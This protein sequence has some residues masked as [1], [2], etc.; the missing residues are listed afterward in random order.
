MAASPSGSSTSPQRSDYSEI[1]PISATHVHRTLRVYASCSDT[2]DVPSV[3]AVDAKTIVIADDTAFVR[4]RFKSALQ[5]AGHRATTVASA[6]ELLSQIRTHTGLVHLVVLDLRLPQAQGVALVRALRAIDGFKAPI[7]VFSGTIANADEV[8]EL[9]ALGIAG[10]INEYSAVQNIVPALA[11]HLFPEQH[12]RR[13]GPRVVLGIPVAYRLANTIAAALTLNIS[14]GGLAI[15]TT[16]PLDT[17]TIVKVRFRLP[18]GAKDVDAEARVAWADR[19]T[20][21]G[22]QFTKVTPADQTTIDDF[23]RKH[24]FSNRK[25]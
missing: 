6:N 24:F 8:R 20:G 14:H 17:G 23:V 15:R 13:M 21:M 16:N 25:A 4:D 18:G 9:S 22:L 7:M 12:N 10:Y 2:S 3:T 5:S 19:R 11:P 1:P